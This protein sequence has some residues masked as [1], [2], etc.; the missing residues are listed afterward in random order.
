MQ[1]HIFLHWL[2]DRRKLIQI[3]GS[4]PRKQPTRKEVLDTLNVKDI[5]T[6]LEGTFQTKRTTNPLMP[7]YII[8]GE[9][10]YLVRLARFSWI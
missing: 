3:Q 4:V 7:E 6:N 1:K 2:F 9:N 5:N 10:K 8:Q